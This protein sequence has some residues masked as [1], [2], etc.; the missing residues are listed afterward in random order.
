MIIL[1]TTPSPLGVK[2]YF[3][4]LGAM[5]STALIINYNYGSEGKIFAAQ[6]VVVEQV[7]EL[8]AR[9]R[10]YREKETRHQAAE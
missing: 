3:V 5:H 7:A 10:K 4:S 6:L 2:S 1:L 8:F 9:A